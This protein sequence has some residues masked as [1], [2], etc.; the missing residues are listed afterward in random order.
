MIHRAS[1]LPTLLAALEGRAGDIAVLPL[2]PG[3]GR[4]AK[5]VILQARHGR[6]GPA[7]LLPGLTLH[8]AAGGDTAAARAIL[9]DGAPLSLAD[10]G[11]TA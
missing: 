9:R 7:R 10:E 6:R 3:S 4:P 1:R 2:W 11:T 5:R 8:D